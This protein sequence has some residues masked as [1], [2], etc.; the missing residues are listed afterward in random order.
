MSKTMDCLLVFS[1]NMEVIPLNER[2]INISRYI[3]IYQALYNDSRIV[4]SAVYTFLFADKRY[5]K[6][7]WTFARVTRCKA[8]ANAAVLKGNL[9]DSHISQISL[10]EFVIQTSSFSLTSSSVHL[11]FCKFCTHS[12]NETV[13][14]PPFV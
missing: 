2:T 10:K 1:V 4:K 7:R 14:P 12:K 5:S 13:T 6:P 3:I 9:S 8:F 11:K